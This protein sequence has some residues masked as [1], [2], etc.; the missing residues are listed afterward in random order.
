MQSRSSTDLNARSQNH[1]FSV[2]RSNAACKAERAVIRDE[3]RVATAVARSRRA[4][5]ANRNQAT[6]NWR[7]FH[8]RIDALI[9]LFEPVCTATPVLLQDRLCCHR[10]LGLR[11]QQQVKRGNVRDHQRRYINDW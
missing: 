5:A 1:L 11:A 7:Q 6:S 4:L 10:S 2:S 8:S 9:L 3:S